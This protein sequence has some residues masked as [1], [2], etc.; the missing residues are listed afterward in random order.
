MN[1]SPYQQFT[2]E[3]SHDPIINAKKAF[4]KIQHSSMMKTPIKTRNRGEL[5]QLNQIDNITLK[6]ERLNAFPL[7]LGKR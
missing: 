7:R 4:D 3:K 5:P 1:N 2:A 6:G